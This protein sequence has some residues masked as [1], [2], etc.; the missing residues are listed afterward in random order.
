MIIE[1]TALSWHKDRYNKVILHLVLMQNWLHHRILSILLQ[2]SILHT[3]R[4]CKTR[5]F[6]MGCDA[7]WCGRS[8]PSFR[9][10]PC[11]P[12]RQQSKWDLNFTPTH[13]THERGRLK[14]RGQTG[15]RYGY[16]Y[17]HCVL[18]LHTTPQLR[19]GHVQPINH[20]RQHSM[21]VYKLCVC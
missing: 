16:C 12:R 10:K 3:R 18:I 14:S 19:H 9:R 4:V 17:D 13:R 7:V 8:V 5:L 2:Y 1:L 6:S 11:Y 15:K 21:D 20:T